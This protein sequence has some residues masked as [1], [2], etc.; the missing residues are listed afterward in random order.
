MI[1]V[2]LMGLA[3]TTS[4][5]KDD[6]DDNK[7]HSSYQVPTDNTPRYER[8]ECTSCKGTGICKMA[9]LGCG[10]T[11]N[12]G[13][14]DG[15]GYTGSGSFTIKCIRCNGKKICKYCEGTGECSS[16]DGYGY[17]EVEVKP[18]TNYDDDDD[19]NYS[20][21]YISI[22]ALKISAVELLSGEWSYSSSTANMYIKK[23]FD[24]EMIL[25]SSSKSVV[26]SVSIN[27]DR[28]MGGINVSSYTYRVLGNVGPN[29]MTYYYF[30]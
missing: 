13:G 1:F 16:C 5:S 22:K 11:G 12:C 24:G 20:N 6:D 19:N 14:C 23:R 18:S 21:D 17:K 4:C 2:M 10:G 9:G 28:S 8:K 29:S 15:K 30:N 27:S 3:M 25:Y 26:G 7:S